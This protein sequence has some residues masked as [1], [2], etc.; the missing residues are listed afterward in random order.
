VRRP[1]ASCVILRRLVA[2]A[3]LVVGALSLWA[4]AAAGTR[5][6][7][8][9]VPIHGTIDAGMAHLVERAVDEARTSG[10][11]AIVLDVN[12]FGGLVS[13]GTEIR[14]TLLGAGIPV[15]AYVT[16]AWSAGALVTLAADRI[17]MSPGGSIGAAEPIPKTV[18]T[19]SAL[20]SEF[21]STA[22]RHHRNATL[23][24]DVVHYP[25]GREVGH[26]WAQR[27]GVATQHYGCRKRQRIVLANRPSGLVHDSQA[28]YVRV[29]GKAHVG[30]TFGN[31]RF[32][33]A[34]ISRDG[35]RRMREAAVRLEVDR[36]HPAAKLL[37]QCRHDHSA[38]ATHT[39][40]RHVQLPRAR[41][42]NVQV[43]QRKDTRDMARDRCIV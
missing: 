25:A 15:D 22:L 14:D 40:Q 23:G 41:C 12:T 3:C 1:V 38:G 7:V 11:V 6:A 32:E 21:S 35:L 36:G 13:A 18:K 8:V 39:I 20:R 19:V 27:A 34:K 10:A 2:L 37:E 42:L 29:S 9:I 17:V 4:P 26:Y 16:R 33:L 43:W 24:G 30:P 31:Q 28:V 5:G